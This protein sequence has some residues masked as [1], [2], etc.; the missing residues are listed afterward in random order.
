[1]STASTLERQMLALVNSERAK[2]GLQPV[3]L[4]LRL[5]D[6]AEDHSRWML[7]TDTFSHTGVG[8]SSATQRMRDAGF[9][10]SGDWQ[11]AENI[12]WQSV[13]GASGLA[14]DVV[15][16]HTG[17]MN[18]RGHRDNI[19][20]PNVTVIGIGIETG[21]FD[22]YSAIMVTQNFA[23]TTAPVQLDT[24]G[25]SSGSGTP[26]APSASP[27]ADTT[28]SNTADSE[29]TASDPVRKV[30]SGNKKG[31]DG[32]DW[33]VLKKGKKLYGEDGDDILVGSSKGNKLYGGEGDDKLDGRSGNDRIYAGTGDDYAKG[34]GGKDKLYGQDGNDRL[35]GGGKKDKLYGGNG[36]DYLN[37]GGGKDKLYGGNGDDNLRGGGGKDKLNGGAGDDVMTG[38]GGA[39]KFIYTSGNDR[40]TDLGKKDTVDIRSM[41]SITSFRDLK[42][43][44][45]QQSGSDVLIDDGEGNT[46]RLEGFSLSSLDDDYFII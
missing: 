7:N 32:D 21:E 9:N 36:E 29:D 38:G 30:V 15:D 22:G 14:D 2:N 10:F 11:S 44:H 41:D 37:G 31:T 8:G 42:A 6:A 24:G 39:D 12:A 5:N 43:N 46:L 33:L 25:P 23:R 27:A 16:L 26:S 17:L 13:R 3:R 45:A 34:G 1:M 4:E 35:Y 19:L 40:I 18:S 28:P 20:D